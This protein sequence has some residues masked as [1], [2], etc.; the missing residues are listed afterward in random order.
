MEGDVFMFKKQRL[1]ISSLAIT[2]FV[3]LEWQQKLQL[4]QQRPL[5]SLNVVQVESELGG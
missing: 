3:G 4:D 5:T 1:G 2:A